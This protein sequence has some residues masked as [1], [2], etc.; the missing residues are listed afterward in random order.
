MLKR[1][2]QQQLAA[3][4]RLKITFKTAAEEIGYTPVHVRNYFN[5]NTADQF[6]E[7][8]NRRIGEPLDRFIDDQIE[9]AILKVRNSSDKE[10]ADLASLRVSRV[11]PEINGGG[12]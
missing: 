6:S 12:E 9:M 10:I 5:E 8:S 4:K 2:K 7:K 11:N 3:L 1:T